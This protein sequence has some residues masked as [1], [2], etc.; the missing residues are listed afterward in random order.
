MS[1]PCRLSLTG[2]GQSP[3]EGVLGERVTSPSGRVVREESHLHD[4]VLRAEPYAPRE[5]VQLR[6]SLNALKLCN[7]SFPPAKVYQTLRITKLFL[8]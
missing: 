2:Q 8:S 3:A 6:S 7:Q 4:R 1:E 5:S